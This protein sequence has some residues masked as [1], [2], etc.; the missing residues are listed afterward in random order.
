MERE[1]WIEVVKLLRAYW[2]QAALPDETIAVWFVDVEELEHEQVR[3]ALHAFAREGREFP[4][5]GGML[6]KKALEL[7]RPIGAGNWS[8]AI[9][10][11]T[12]E[13]PSWNY[14]PEESLRTLQKL[15]PIA[16]ET[17][18]RFGIE[19]WGM[20]TQDGAHWWQARFRD[21]YQE[22]AR[23]FAERRELAGL[24]RDDDG[25]KLRHGPLRR[26]GERLR[27]LPPG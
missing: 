10:L 16:A 6:R 22:V 26:L 24:K 11:A 15:D 18:L 19:E 4:P 25:R 5:T 8:K 20:R 3:A 7:A 13:V 14:H 27:E 12:W 2:P 23:E 17:V 9:D 21:I 1:E